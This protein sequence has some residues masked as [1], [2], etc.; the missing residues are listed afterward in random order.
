MTPELALTIVAILVALISSMV[1]SAAF[2]R[3]DLLEFRLQ[4]AEQ[5]TA[6]SLSRVFETLS[7][8]ARIQ[9]RTLFELVFVR[10][11]FYATQSQPARPLQ[12]EGTQASAEAPTV[13]PVP[14]SHLRVVGRGRTDDAAVQAVEAARVRADGDEPSGEGVAR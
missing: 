10:D 5:F 11:Q 7:E 12:S 2:R 8:H 13:S 9:K 1:A 4:N 14:V 3:A 6:H